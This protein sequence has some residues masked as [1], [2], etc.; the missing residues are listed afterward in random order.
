MFY[1]VSEINGTICQDSLIMT[2]SPSNEL[3]QE[4]CYPVNRTQIVSS[5]LIGYSKTIASSGQFS[6]Q[7]SHSTQASGSVT[8]D[9]LSS[10]VKHSLGHTSTH[11]PQP[12]HLASSTFGGI[13]SFHPSS[14]SHYE[15]GERLPS[16]DSIC[17][18]IFTLGQSFRI[19]FA[20]ES[21]A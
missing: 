18:L 3:K 12:V 2:T 7:L 21:Q 16:Q 13:V 5:P 6:T 14:F 20:T 4:T 17:F 19:Q 1:R 8:F 15:W 11:V 10:R 9:L